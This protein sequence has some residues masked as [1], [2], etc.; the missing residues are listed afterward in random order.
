MRD[1]LRNEGSTTCFWI[2]YFKGVE[3]AVTVRSSATNA[4]NVNFNNGNVNNNNTYNR[5]FVCLAQESLLNEDEWFDAERSFFKN[6]HGSIGAQQIHIHPAKVIYIAR[7]VK[8]GEYKPQ[9]GYCFPL[10]NPSPR[11]IYAAFCPDRLVHHYVAP[12]IIKV[13]EYIHR[14]NGNISH[15]NRIGYSAQTGAEQIRDAIKQAIE[16]YEDPYI[17]KIDVKSFFTSIS[18]QKA[19]DVFKRFVYEF[20]TGDDLK[21]KLELCKKLILNDPTKGCIILSTPKKWAKIPDRKRQMF[22]KNGCGLPIGN[23]YSQLI[24]NIFLAVLDIILKEYG[25][26]PRF[27]DD[28]CCIVKDKETAVKI[29]HIARAVLNIL[30]LELHPDKIYIQPC[31]RGV[32]FC[33]RTIKG[34]RIYLSNHTINNAHKNIQNIDNICEVVN[35]YLGIMKH[36]TEYKN[37]KRLSDLVKSKYKKVYFVIK[38]GHYICRMHKM[39]IPRIKQKIFLKNIIQKI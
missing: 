9:P 21:E 23:F 38:K 15:G 13:A 19:F 30:D 14:K 18:R 24:A 2:S 26:C 34:N 20:Y 16:L 22:S 33:G 10:L 11:E 3:H 28:K 5:Y 17:V 32:N 1:Q 36:C 29:I 25:I 39:Y 37:E 7:K 8:S 35:S 12:F 6:K 4:W 27:V 31:H